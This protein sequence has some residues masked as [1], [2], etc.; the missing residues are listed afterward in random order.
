MKKILLA[1][2]GMLLS[3][4]VFANVFPDK[5]VKVIVATGP[6]GGLDIMTRIIAKNLEDIWKVP[7]IVENKPGAAAMIATNSLLEAKS[8][9]YTLLFYA[10]TSYAAAQG[11]TKKDPFM[12]EDHLDALAVLH[13]PPFVLVVNSKRN[14]KNLKELAEQGKDK[15]LSYGSTVTGS[16]LH[17]YGAIA[18]EK[19]NVKGILVSYK[20]VPQSIVDVMNNSLDYVVLNWGNVSQHV[21]AGTLTPLF[22]FSEQKLPGY[23]DVPNLSSRNF[24]EY[25]KMI[26]NYNFFIKKDAPEAI[27]LRLQ[28]DIDQAIKISMPE[29]LQKNLV[30]NMYSSKV[31]REEIRLVDR[32]WKSAAEKLAVPE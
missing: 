14:I 3:L 2:A 28:K 31:D 18:A 16:P 20:G 11:M 8:D 9:G 29:L 1:L 17:I 26:G 15:G 13:N 32:L 5:P 12:W 22:V 27:K 25:R 6:G 23:P 21:Q 7:V 10:S 30:G 24:S 4:Q 19:M